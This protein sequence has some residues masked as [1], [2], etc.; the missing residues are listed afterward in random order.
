VG[1]E[2]MTQEH[3]WHA[4]ARTIYE[5]TWRQLRALEESIQNTTIDFFILDIKEALLDLKEA[6]IASDEERAMNHVNEIRSLL[7]EIHRRMGDEQ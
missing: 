5:L 2:A 7:A 3:D 4:T 6:I 1:K